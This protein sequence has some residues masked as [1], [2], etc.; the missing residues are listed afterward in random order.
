MFKK[1]I[2]SIIVASII[3]YLSLTSSDTFDKLPFLNIPFLDK[4]VHFGMYFVLMSV[5]LIENR[6]RNIASRQLFLISLIPFSYGV[7][8]EILQSI[9][10]ASRSA[11]LYDIV[12][13]FA[14]I[15]VSVL[16]WLWIK[17]FNKEIIR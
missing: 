2:Y 15:L 9:L 8:M 4:I 13:N 6:K 7:L 14:G 1:N 10:T 17:P 11:S 5:I 3:L 16:L 12:F